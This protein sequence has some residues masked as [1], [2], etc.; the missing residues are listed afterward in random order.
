MAR[1]RGRTILAAIDIGSYS[2]H[3]LVGRVRGRRVDVVHDESAFLGLGRT[4][5]RTGLLGPARRDLTATLAAYKIAAL[6]QDASAVTVV[7]TDPLRR[8]PDAAEA[9]QEIEAAT[10]LRAAMISHEEEARIALVG[11]TGGRPIVR[12]TA[13]VDVGGGSTEVLVAQPGIDPVAVG[14]PLGATRLTGMHVEHDPPTPLE[15]AAMAAIARAAMGDAPGP[16]PAEAIAVG[17]TARSLLRVGPPLSNRALGRHRIEN[18]LA[19]VGGSPSA[20]IAQRY[21]IRPSRA[22]VLAAGA[23]ILHAA[24]ERYD[25][26]HLRVARG[27]LRE[28][29]ILA[30]AQAGPD[31]RARLG[32]LARGWEH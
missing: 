19:L 25:L 1:G 28:G 17:G 8:A 2:V 32:E 11:V 22:A 26:D 10:G 30:T 5:D 31:W 7:G 21:S 20:Q 12:S 9:I 4:I 23:T 3:L 29:L 13:V 24:L 15:L 18:A 27:G 16:A 14:L 6:S